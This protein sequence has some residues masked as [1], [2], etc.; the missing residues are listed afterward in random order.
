ME[1]YLKRTLTGLRPATDEDAEAL[2]KY[3]LDSVVR[4]EIVRQRNYKFL[5]KMHVLFRLAFDYWTECEQIVMTDT[6][7]ILYS[8]Y[9]TYRGQAVQHSIERFRHDLVILAGHYTPVFNLRGEVR[10]EAKS[11]SYARCSEED[12]EKIYSD[13]INVILRYVYKHNT[14]EEELRKMVDQVMGFV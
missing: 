14:S 12:A 9:A 8:K 1:I 5:Q 13:V 11:I 10:L 4:C 2:T 6:G 3:P 7:T